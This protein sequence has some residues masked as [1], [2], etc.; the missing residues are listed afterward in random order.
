M[1]YVL[2]ILLFTHYVIWAQFTLSGSTI[3]HSGT[4]TVVSSTTISGTTKSTVNGKVTVFDFGGKT[5][6]ANGTINLADGV[7]FHN[8]ILSN[9]STGTINAGVEQSNPSDYK[10]NYGVDM[11]SV[12]NSS[13]IN[14]AVK[15]NIYG[16]SAYFNSN[17]LVISSTTVEWKYARV[18]LDGR[19]DL[20]GSGHVVENSHI[21]ITGAF[22]NA[23]FVVSN[24]GSWIGNV[25]DA[26]DTNSYFALS[27]GTATG[28][29]NYSDITLL[30]GQN[31]VSYGASST[32]V[33]L[34][35]TNFSGGTSYTLDSTTTS[36]IR[37]FTLQLNQGFK[38]TVQDDAFN[39]IE[40]AKVFLDGGSG[41]TQSINTN[42]Q[43]IA[44]QTFLYHK[45]VV[46]G[47]SP[48]TTNY[49]SGS[50]ISKRV[51]AYAYQISQEQVVD[52]RTAKRDESLI[53][54]LND[55]NISEATKATVDAYTEIDNLDKLYDRAKSWKIEDSNLGYPSGGALLVTANNMSTVLD[56]GN[57]DLVID[58]S[59]AS[60][61]AVDKING[62]ITIK[63]STLFVGSRFNGVKTTGTISTANG[64]TIE[65]G[66]EDSTGINKYFHL[67]WVRNVALDVSVENLDDTSK[68]VNG[69]SA[70]K[71]YKGHF[72]MPNPAPTAGVEM[73]LDSPG[74]FRMYQE[75]FPEADL[76]FTRTNI[77]L[78][79]SEERQTEMLFLTRKLLQKSEGI[80]EAL[81]G[82]TPS[83][84]DNTTI[85]TSAA[86]A[87]NENQV[88][89]L[90][91]LRRIMKKVSA[92]KE[93]LEN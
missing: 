75:I 49:I 6:V 24:A 7:A 44:E 35:L 32:N 66:Y 70:T 76:N 3:T 21:I 10:Y 67:D 80:N 4:N 46:S 74:G 23:N 47:G 86:G 83:I 56:L 17:F 20:R 5:L 48:S 53:G 64:A 90:Q 18:H 27:T 60:A 2:G 11:L 78:T 30:T 91:L 65:H 16:Q 50:T 39:V 40:G 58:A 87:T 61:F 37:N 85:T 15:I 68:I 12:S 55:P 89:I 69:V 82:N 52:V 57:H 54:L 14:S 9:T 13:D 51:Y 38:D 72:V 31:L 84:T 36:G 34:N 88:A 25:V 79:V 73:Q 77:T 1:K 8:F 93:A 41:T 33:I 29:Y 19:L 26:E 28:T 43:G 92:N 63:A 62:V 42:T 71:T 22:P 59:A 45:N 81:T